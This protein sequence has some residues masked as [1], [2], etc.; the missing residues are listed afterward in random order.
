[1]KKRYN[2]FIII[3]VF[4]I[5]LSMFFSAIFCYVYSKSVPGWFQGGIISFFISV[6]IVSILI[7]LIKTIVK[8]LLRKHLIFRPLLIIDY[9]FFFLNYVL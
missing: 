3:V 7:P 8:I 1:M 6:F 4:L 9:C 5:L 2:I